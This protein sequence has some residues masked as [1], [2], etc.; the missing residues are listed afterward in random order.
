[1]KRFIPVILIIGLLLTGCATTGGGKV[2]IMLAALLQMEQEPDDGG[3]LGGKPM[4]PQ[5]AH[6]PLTA[7]VDS[8][9]FS[10]DGRYA[11]SGLNDSTA[12]IWDISQA[13][14]AGILKG[15]K[16]SVLAVAFSGD[17]NKIATGSSDGKIIL[18]DVHTGEEIRTH[19]TY[20]KGVNKVSFSADGRF[21]LAGT[22]D[23]Q[24][25]V[26]DISPGGKIR[27]FKTAEHAGDSRIVIPYAFS[28]DGRYAL[29]ATS[30][31]TVI[32]WDV[33]SGKEMKKFSGSMGQVISLAFSADGSRALAGNTSGDIILLDVASGTVAQTLEGHGSQVRAVAFSGDGRYAVSGSHD[34]TSK[35]WDIASGKVI[36]TMAGHT[37]V[38]KSIAMSP[39]Q[40]LIATGSTDGTTKFWNARTGEEIVAMVKP[41]KYL[42]PMYVK[43]NVGAKEDAFKPLI[44]AW[45]M[46]TPDGY[47]NGSANALGN[48]NVLTGL[49][50]Y[51]IDQFYDV[52]YR[53]DIIIARL[54]GEDTK[55][56]VTLTL[57][58]ALKNPPPDVDISSVPKNT[59][60]AFIKVDYSVESNGG[61]IGEVRIFHNGKLVKSDGYYREIKRPVQDKVTLTAYSAKALREDLRGVAI[62]AKKEG[63]VSMIESAPKGNAFKGSITV[64]AIPGENEIALAA[65]NKDNT[66]QS[67]LKTVKFNSSRPP[68]P[69]NVYLLAIGI[70]E[71]K[72]Q[73]NNLKYAV[74]DASAFAK[75]F[76][77]KA[78]TLYQSA[79]VHVDVLKNRQATKVHIMEKLS[80][81]IK[82]VKPND[83]F[84]MFTASHGI[85]HSGLYSIVTH[86][87]DG[88][89]RSDNVINS[90]EIM[91]TSKNMKALTQIFI[92]DTCYAGGLDNFVSGL[93][94]ARMSVMARNMGLHMFASASSTQ[95]ALD[96]YKGKNGMFTYA[97]L[98]GLNDNRQA[99]R[100]KDK[101][102]S[103]FELGAY[104][105]DQTIKHSHEAGHR[106]T[107]VIN[108]FGKDIPVYNLH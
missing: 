53:P 35:L 107:P 21:L 27:S 52:F 56:W 22:D 16:A 32:L 2:E 31:R 70:D 59:D 30:D 41:V 18:W 92:L 13:R 54:R 14:N 62:V 106:Q 72:A 76:K 9:A 96:G 93:Y 105:K 108:N 75:K 86:D 67:M 51:T 33:R 42:P 34:N 64:E 101:R 10:P 60:E 80:E 43:S 65:F 99:D 29:S 11:A 98:E 3:G 102:I 81:Y 6:M 66:V 79:H 46:L 87:Y 44:D 49:A 5:T 95:E 97:L 20:S 90:N 68:V 71:Y 15:H 73:G 37:N 83:V 61:G 12:I 4:G 63:K 84:V 1:M 89:L 47:Y 7:L 69:A 25:V 74:K 39:N 88:S 78:A 26:W 40:I 50:T 24:I 8:V 57:E 36:K 17:S 94:D 45:V 77:E 23:Q 38:I 82:K 19:M 58:D 85:L 48:L 28:N 55:D 100:N 91:E 103:V 104:A